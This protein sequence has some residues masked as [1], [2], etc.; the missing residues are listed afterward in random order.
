MN[1]PYL[2]CTCAGEL[3]RYRAA[4]LRDS[5]QM[6]EQGDRIPSLDTLNFVMESLACGHSVMSHRAAHEAMLDTVQGVT[7]E[8]AN[9]L[10]R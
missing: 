10:A 6:A 7:L 8:A 5:A 2:P 1:V 9:A 4:I 3:D